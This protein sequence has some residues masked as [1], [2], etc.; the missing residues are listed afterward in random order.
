MGS[1]I[2]NGRSASRALPLPIIGAA[3]WRDLVREVKKHHFGF[4]LH[5][6]ITAPERSETPNSHT[7]FF[8]SS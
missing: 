8:S 1:D 7:H 4:R 5:P 3:V 2:Q 6:R